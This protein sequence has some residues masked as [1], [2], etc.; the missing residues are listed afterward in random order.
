MDK[1]TWKTRKS[2]TP[3]DSLRSGALQGALRLLR[4]ATALRGDSTPLATAQGAGMAERFPSGPSTRPGTPLFLGGC[5]RPPRFLPFGTEKADYQE[6][7][8]PE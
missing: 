3:G 6:I 1:S 8:P 4:Y 7:N 5:Y 2:K